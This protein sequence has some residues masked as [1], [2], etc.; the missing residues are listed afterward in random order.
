MVKSHFIKRSILIILL[1]IPIL[2]LFI[3]CSSNN[4]SKIT[5]RFLKDFKSKNFE[6]SYTYLVEDDMS[7][8]FSEY[9]GLFMRSQGNDSDK[10]VDKLNDVIL[11]RIVNITYDI[12]SEVKILDDKTKQV[13]V[14]IGYYDISDAYDNAVEEF[15]SRSLDFDNLDNLYNIDTIVNI[16]ITHINNLKREEEDIDVSLIKDD[17]S[18]EIQMNE[19][20]LDILVGNSVDILENFK[21]MIVNE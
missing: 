5:D 19:Q 12:G 3:S 6:E 18:W 16:L 11:D 14:K 7:K 21:S 20:L 17:G 9:I 1:I 4:I 8:K 15:L 10:N 2:F 13:E